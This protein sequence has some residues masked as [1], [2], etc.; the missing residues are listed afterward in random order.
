VT[1]GQI[2]V[3]MK[4]FRDDLNGVSSTASVRSSSSSSTT[5]SSSVSSESSESSS[6]ASSVTAPEEGAIRFTTPTYSVDEDK[7]EATVSLIRTGGKTGVVT[8]NYKTTSKTA[9]APDDFTLSSGKLTFA[10]NET[11]RSFTIPIID[12]GDV[13]DDETV[14]LE[15]TDPDGGAILGD[16]VVATLTIKDNDG[17][18]GSNSQNGTFNFSASEYKVP[19]NGGSITI[20]VERTGGTTGEVT[21]DYATSDSTAKTGTNYSSASDTLT[22][23]AGESVKTFTVETVLNEEING[24]KTVI[25][26]LSNPTGGAV[27]GDNVQV[28]LVIVD[29]EVSTYGV[30]SIKFSSS[31]FTGSEANGKIVVSVERI[32]GADGEVTIDYGTTDG[33]AIAGADYTATSGTLTFKDGETKKSFVIPVTED[34]KSD[35]GESINLSISNPGGGATLASPSIATGTIQ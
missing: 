13:E 24:N 35:P 16:P 7:G 10:E 14:E 11:G 31:G 18:G 15:L 6:S 25:L 33:T 26:K 19:D 3:I 9:A 5:T 21:V 17:A 34:D 23:A 20:T 29:D 4:R 12:D 2:A 22:F 1:R 30:G 8:V 32:G 28:P 27:P